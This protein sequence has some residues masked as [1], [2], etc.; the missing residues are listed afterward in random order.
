MTIAEAIGTRIRIALKAAKM[1]VSE[2][3]AAGLETLSY[4]NLRHAKGL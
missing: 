2:I 1:F 4:E 3:N